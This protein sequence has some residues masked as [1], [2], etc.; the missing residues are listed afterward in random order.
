M[1]TFLFVPTRYFDFLLELNWSYA[2]R[3]AG[4]PFLSVR[5]F[6]PFGAACGPGSQG[7]KRGYTKQKLH[8][9]I[10]FLLFFLDVGDL[11]DYQLVSSVQNC[12]STFPLFWVHNIKNASTQVFTCLPCCTVLC[13]LLFSLHMK[14]KEVIYLFDFITLRF[15]YF[16]RWIFFCKLWGTVVIC[17]CSVLLQIMYP[18][19]SRSA[20]N[21]HE[22]MA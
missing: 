6:F 15:I 17:Y 2:C 18:C 4:F 12:Y 7:E 1:L 14:C 10:I 20:I 16:I 9:K 21:A 5:I 3:G 19:S 11:H 13:G 8:E 22:E